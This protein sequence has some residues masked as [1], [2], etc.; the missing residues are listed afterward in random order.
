[1]SSFDKFSCALHNLL[2]SIGSFPSKVM[3]VYIVNVCLQ[4]IFF[5]VLVGVQGVK[6]STV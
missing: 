4:I 5:S 1:M 3:H 6:V 2:K